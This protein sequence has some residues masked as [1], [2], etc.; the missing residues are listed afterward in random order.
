MSGQGGLTARAADP[1]CERS[2][3]ENSRAVSRPRGLSA[4][5]ARCDGDE[6]D[7]RH[8]R[9]PRV[10]RAAHP[11]DRLRKP[12][13]LLAGRV[14]DSQRSAPALPLAVTPR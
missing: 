5:P 14:S 6:R 13:L 1:W 12:R 11:I 9:L 10:H 8:A 7:L 3:I 4:R 2:Q